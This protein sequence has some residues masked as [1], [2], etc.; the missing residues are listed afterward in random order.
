MEFTDEQLFR[1]INP[2]SCFDCGKD[3]GCYMIRDEVWNQAVPNYREIKRALREI[4]KIRG[5][6]CLCIDCLELRI[7]RPVG[8]KDFDLS[9]PANYN[10]ALGMKL[11]ARAR[12]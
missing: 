2:C 4:A 1:A 8:V 9:M 11:A 7:G 3:D 5:Y 6:F 12:A 10:I